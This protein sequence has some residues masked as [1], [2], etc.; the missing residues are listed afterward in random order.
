MA[1]VDSEAVP[2]G[3]SDFRSDKDAAVGGRG[4]HRPF[5]TRVRS[6]ATMLTASRW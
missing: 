1:V 2:R 3:V 4:L 5:K 6:K